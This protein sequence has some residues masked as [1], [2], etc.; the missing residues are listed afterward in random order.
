MIM[1]RCV[2]DLESDRNLWIKALGIE[3]REVPFGIENQAIASRTKIVLDEKERSHA[4]ILIRPGV[5]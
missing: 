2:S 1:L 4:A 5:T 3:V